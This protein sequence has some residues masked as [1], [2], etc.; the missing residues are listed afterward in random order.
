MP[1]RGRGSRRERC[2]RFPRPGGSRPYRVDNEAPL[3]PA[4]AGT[5]RAGAGPRRVHGKYPT[6][7]ITKSR[8]PQPRPDPWAGGRTPPGPRRK[9]HRVDNGK[10]A[11][12]RRPGRSGEPGPCA[13]GAVEVDGGPGPGSGVAVFVRGRLPSDCPREGE[14]R[15]GWFRAAVSTG[16]RKA[17]PACNPRHR[18]SPWGRGHD[19]RRYR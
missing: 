19:P 16:L 12:C 7:S 11:P 1:S 10:P 14:G 2:A 17:P 4:P 18:A 5:S 13:A 15:P 8:S 9:P 6:G 3:S